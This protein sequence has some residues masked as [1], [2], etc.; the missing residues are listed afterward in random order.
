MKLT[1]LFEKDE[2]E[3]LEALLKKLEIRVKVL[4][5][6][7]AHVSGPDLYHRRW[8]DEAAKAT[9]EYE[10]VASQIRRIKG[11]RQNEA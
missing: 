4:T 11:R 7:K 5:L 8:V 9:W 10:K 2:L 6:R 3:E 1:F